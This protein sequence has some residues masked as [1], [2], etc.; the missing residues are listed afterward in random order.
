MLGDG[1]VRGSGPLRADHPGGRQLRYLRNSRN[2]RFVRSRPP[3]VRRP[4]CMVTWPDKARSKAPWPLPSSP[5][6][7]MTSPRPTRRSTPVNRLASE[8][9]VDSAE[10]GTAVDL[11]L[12]RS[13]RSGRCRLFEHELDQVCLGLGKAGLANDLAPAHDCDRAAE[14]VDLFELVRHEENHQTLGGELSQSVEEMVRWWPVMPEVGSSRM[15]SLIPRAR[16][17]TISSCWRSPIERLRVTAPGSRRKPSS[18]LLSEQLGGLGRDPTSFPAGSSPDG[19]RQADQRLLCQH[20]DPGGERAGQEI[21]SGSASR[22][23]QIR[24]CRGE[25]IPRGSSSASTSRRR[26]RRARRESARAPVRG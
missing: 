3:T 12:A 13:P 26:S 19:E 10:F 15:S 23:S 25:A 18:R 5:A 24:P 14:L 6:T 20:P 4:F 17:R 21:R 1:Q 8:T 11:S 2:R 22:P 16:S 9:R 7:P